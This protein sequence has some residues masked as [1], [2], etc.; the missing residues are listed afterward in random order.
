MALATQKFVSDIATDAYQYSRMRGSAGGGGGASATS[1]QQAAQMSAAG[2]MAG[3][4]ATRA[5][6]KNKAVL[7]ME[8]LGNALGDAGVNIKRPDF[9][10]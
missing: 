5:A 10:R 2:N 3:A 6:D 9:Y 1:T 4:R 8:D 7:T